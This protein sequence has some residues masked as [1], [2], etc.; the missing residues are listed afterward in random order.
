MAWLVT[1]G[2]GYIGVHVV[3]ALKAS[4]LDVVVLDDLS[5]G[6]AHLVDAPLVVGDVGDDA[7][8]ERVMT[9]YRIDGVL[10]FAARKQVAESVA[11][12]LGYYSA[13][14]GSLVTLLEAMR[15][16]GVDLLVFSS[17]AAVYG[18]PDVPL[19]TEETATLPVSPYG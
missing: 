14:V 2:A 15:R 17:S 5:T 8:L 7:V 6:R 1:G 13:N 3:P 4:G 11:D 9:E 12:P 16:H 18:S 19:V 10:H